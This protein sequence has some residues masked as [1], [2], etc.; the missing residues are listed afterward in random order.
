[1]SDPLIFVLPGCLRCKWLEFARHIWLMTDARIAILQHTNG[2]HTRLVYVKSCRDPRLNNPSIFGTSSL[3][4][5]LRSGRRRRRRSLVEQ[6]PRRPKLPRSPKE[7]G[8]TTSEELVV[9]LKRGRRRRKPKMRAEARMERPNWRLSW[10]ASSNHDTCLLHPLASIFHATESI[11]SAQH[12]SRVLGSGVN[13][14]QRT[15][16][17]PILR[18]LQCPL[19]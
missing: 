8:S 2:L 13:E 3:P 5:S 7:R 10:V 17:L 14:R 19:Q 9:T 16:E 12:K 18:G 15:L 1:M 11:S 4:A 6:M